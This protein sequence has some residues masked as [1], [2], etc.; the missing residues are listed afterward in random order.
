MNKECALRLLAFTILLSI[1][2]AAL[3]AGEP[4]TNTPPPAGSPTQPAAP[5]TPAAAAAPVPQCPAICI[6]GLQDSS[7]HTVTVKDPVGKENKHS[8]GLNHELLIKVALADAQKQPY[9]IDAARYVLF[10]NGREVKGLD[11]PTYDSARQSLVFALKRNDKNKELW[12]TLLGSPAHASVPVSV[13]LGERPTDGAASRPSMFGV[14]PTNWS[15]TLNLRVFSEWQLTAAI[16]A[17]L[18]MVVFVWGRARHSATLRDNLLPQ[19]EPSRQTY[20]LGRWQMAFWFTLIFGSFVFLFLL[21]WDFNTVS[22]QALKLM[23]ISVVTALGAVAVDVYKNS[24]ADACNQGLRALGLNSYADVVRVHQEIT[25]RNAEL[26]QLPPP[27]RKTQLE[28]EILDRQLILRTYE[29]KIRPFVTEGWFRDLT[30]DLNGTA[31]HRL[32][33]FLW[34]WALGAVFI[35]GVYRDLAMPDFNSTLLALMA[36]SSAGYVGFKFPEVN[37]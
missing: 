27:P 15:S 32:Q 22:A 30:T 17:L 29:D 24:P 4:P 34:T 1:G 28:A 37:N 25:A 18:V 21:L 26:A 5:A 23:G 19:L 35:I 11:D 14:D 9:Q 16:F 8:L 33:V 13:S 10:F 12:T 2:I 36:I 7:G 6:T 20:S 3:P 31:I